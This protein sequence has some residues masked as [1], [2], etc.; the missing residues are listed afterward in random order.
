MYLRLLIRS[1]TPG[2]N[3]VAM[4]SAMAYNP[5]GSNEPPPLVRA[6][7]WVVKEEYIP[8]AG[9]YRRQL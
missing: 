6:S 3:V 4:R 5:M 9:E 1:L 7:S 8:F 2:T